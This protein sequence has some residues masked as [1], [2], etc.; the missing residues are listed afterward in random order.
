MSN[1]GNH[2]EML[3]LYKFKPCF[4]YFTVDINGP[5]FPVPCFPITYHS[6]VFSKYRPTLGGKKTTAAPTGWCSTL[7]EVAL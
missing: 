7:S 1:M 3:H 2:D 6:Q 5:I 4:P